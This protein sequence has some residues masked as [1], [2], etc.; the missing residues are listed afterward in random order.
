M[1]RILIAAALAA[2]FTITTHAAPRWNADNIAA[3]AAKAE[4]EINE[5]LQKGTGPM[6]QLMPDGDW[7]DWQDM[8][9]YMENADGFSHRKKFFPIERLRQKRLAG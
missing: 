2:V 5:Y 8:E 3:A 7:Q 9:Y 1:K 4:A 6:A